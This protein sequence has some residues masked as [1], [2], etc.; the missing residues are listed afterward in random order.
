MAQPASGTFALLHRGSFRTFLA[1]GALQFAAAPALFVLLMFQI[2]LAYPASE[3]ETYGALALAFLGLAS[4]LPTLASAFFAGS[5][6]DRGDRGELMRFAN[7]LSL[8]ATAFLGADLYFSPGARLATPGPPGFYLPSWVVLAYPGWALFTASA[9]IFRPAYN[10]SVPRFVSTEE[11]G[12]ANGLIYATAAACVTVTTVS[13]GALLSAASAVEAVLLPFALLF[14]TQVCLVGLRVELTVT[15][16]TPPRSVMSSVREGFSFLLKRRDLFEMTVAA[17]VMNFLVALALV[18]LALYVVSWLGLVSGIW[19]GAVTA[20][21]TA[22]SGVG[23]LSASRLSFEERAGRL[24]IGLVFVAGLA[25]IGLAS[26]RSV[27]L[28]LPIIFGYG[29]ATGMISTMFL[30]TVQATVPDQMMGRVFAADEVGSYALVP[31]GQWVGGLVT[32]VLGVQRTYLATGLALALFG[33]LM[34]LSFRALRRFGY[35][36]AASAPSRGSE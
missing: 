32:V 14:V 21:A 31:V 35:R 26:V 29:V 25:L 19:Y 18:E 33:V 36:A 4:T 30:S 3:R 13:Q 7:V 9:T 12:R 2:A 23:L 5:L 28:S 24:I 34:L 6:A 20:A 22:G 10:T 27:W 1:A 17:L 16:T 11:L 8:L 15:R